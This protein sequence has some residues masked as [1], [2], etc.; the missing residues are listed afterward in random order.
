MSTPAEI[1]ALS[2]AQITSLSQGESVPTTTFILTPPSQNNATL[3][4]GA[5]GVLVDNAGNT[6][7]ISNGQVTINGVAD[8]TTANVIDLAFVKGVIWQQN[9]SKLWWSKASPTAAWTPQAGTS[10]N[11]IT[12]AVP[13]PVVV[14]ANGATIKAPTSAVLTDAAG[15][16]W[17]INTSGLVTINGTADTTTL[18]V[19]L[20][21]YV[22]GAI[23]QQNASG[24]WWS[25]A[26]PSA[27]W[28]PGPGTSVSPLT[29]PVA[30]TLL[31]AP[32]NFLLTGQSQ[33]GATLSWDSVSGAVEYNVLRAVGNG[34]FQVIGNTKTTTYA[35]T[36]A[37]N[38]TVP[39]Q[40]GPA[41]IYSY[42]VAAVG[43]N[44]Q[45][46]AIQ[47]NMT[48]WVYNAGKFYW[49]GDYSNC[50]A[51]YQ[52]LSGF[53]SV[54]GEGAWAW[55]QPYSGAPFCPQW[56]MEGG[57]AKYFTFDIKVIDPA[58]LNYFRL[59][60][61]SRLPQGDVYNNASVML[62][63]ES[64]YPPLKLNEFVTIKVPLPALGIGTGTCVGGISGSTL[65]VTSNNGVF[66]QATD[67]IS[68]GGLPVPLCVNSAANASN[69]PGAYALNGSANIPANTTFDTQR[70]NIYKVAFLDESTSSSLRYYL[71]NVALTNF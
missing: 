18:N 51:N 22:N 60:I 34:P 50:K 2:A 20:L 6:W 70:T 53:L 11:P 42:Q 4:A 5:S 69:G 13:P 35:D 31:P 27:A 68:G 67:W 30:P 15:N 7:G 56:S 23:W 66:D 46:G 36:N 24:L 58:I 14:S 71:N 55:Y 32:A 39:N 64:T 40:S 26:N 38:T 59:N 37:P 9:A 54:T 62:T 41:T 8:S 49:P 65:T 10:T 21:A 43:A 61:I 29:P 47:A 57:W 63:G 12:G 25:K 17:G 19:T 28:L 3:A 45:Q 16:T 52:D 44:G 48:A 1:V 33:N